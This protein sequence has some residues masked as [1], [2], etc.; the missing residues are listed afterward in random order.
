M[1]TDL[2]YAADA[3]VSLSYDEL[4][5]RVLLIPFICIIQ[6]S[7]AITLAGPLIAIPTHP[8][9][10][11]DSPD[12]VQLRTGPCESPVCEHQVEE[13]GQG[14]M[15]MTRKGNTQSG[16]SNPLLLTLVLH[17]PASRSL[18]LLTNSGM[19]LRSRSMLG[20]TSLTLR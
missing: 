3:Q 5:V 7:A 17:P 8:V 12:H 9:A 11:H 13:I 16:I 19:W 18:T 15:A 2:P 20:L 14:H 6:H 1:S 10:H 4:E